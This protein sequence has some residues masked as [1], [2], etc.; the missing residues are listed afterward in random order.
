MSGFKIQIAQ[1]NGNAVATAFLGDE[2]HVARDDHPFWNRIVDVHSNYVKKEPLGMTDEEA[3]NLLHIPTSLKMNF[4]KLS[5]RFSIEKG[6]IYY[7]GDE[8]HNAI[9][10]QILK[11]LDDGQPIEAIVNFAENIM[12]NPQEH[13]RE[14]LFKWLDANDFDITNSG[15]IVVYKGCKSLPNADALEHGCDIQSSHSGTDEVI[16]T[17]AAG[18]SFKVTGRVP[19][20]ISGTVEMARKLVHH[21]PNRACDHGLHVGTLAYAKAF[22]RERLVMALVNPRDVVSVPTDST[23]IVAAENQKM[24]VSRYKVVEEI[25]EN[26]DK[27]LTSA[28]KC[29]EAGCEVHTQRCSQPQADCVYDG[30]S[31]PPA[32]YK[33]P[34][35]PV[36]DQSKA[37]RWWQL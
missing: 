11:V 17:N 13:S 35:A 7:D 8:L 18:K 20:P 34:A 37:K 12:L 2:S 27:K 28:E 1:I 4:K 3:F 24:R 36:K 31:T 15:H 14:Q 5:E 21:D 26:G 29:A 32:Q 6:V 25:D 23:G 10:K 30:V 16:V 9:S 22:S 33:E 19:Q